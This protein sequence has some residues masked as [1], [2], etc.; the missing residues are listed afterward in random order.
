LNFNY[1][2]LPLRAECGVNVA[3]LLLGLGE[4]TIP[5]TICEAISP[6]A[7]GGT[8]TPTGLNAFSPYPFSGNATP[9][10]ND[11]NLPAGFTLMQ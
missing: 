4:A 5:A 8:Q 1:F 7:T 11:T 3:V 9:Q 10:C 2:P 6:V